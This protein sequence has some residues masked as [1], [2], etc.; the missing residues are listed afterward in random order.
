MFPRYRF[1]SAAAKISTAVALLP[2][3]T[4]GYREEDDTASEDASNQSIM[5]DTEEKSS[6]LLYQTPQIEKD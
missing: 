5:G 1:S 3:R 2:T 4:V 6:F